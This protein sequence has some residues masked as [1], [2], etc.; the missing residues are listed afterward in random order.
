MTTQ[1]FQG[2]RLRL[3]SQRGVGLIEILVAV[4]ILSLGLLGMAG[5]QANALKA[6]QGSYTRT[7]AVMLSYY[8]L[9]AMRADRG[10]A[11][12]LSYN[13]N[14]TCLPGAITTADLAGNTRRQWLTSLRDNL[15]DANTTCGAIT[16]DADGNCTVSITWDDSRAAGGTA[17]TIQT[18]ETRSR[19]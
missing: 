6:N 10:N 3:E 14:A 17:Q 11:I 15:G 12:N 7:Q 4:L 2:P 18:F 13:M 19:I 1:S 5:L 8:I 9:D 16:C